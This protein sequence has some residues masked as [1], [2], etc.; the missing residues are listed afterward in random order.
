MIP[1]VFL[2]H[3][4][5]LKDEEAVRKAVAW[6]LN[7]RYPFLVDPLPLGAWVLKSEESTS[8]EFQEWYFSGQGRTKPQ[9]ATA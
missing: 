8:K 6:F 1:D 9:K 4:S 5:F 3:I 2:S 7:K